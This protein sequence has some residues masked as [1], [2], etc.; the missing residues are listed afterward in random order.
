MMQNCAARLSLCIACFA[1]QFSSAVLAQVK[2]DW[3]VLRIFVPEEE[4][5]SLVPKDYNP[6]EIEDL[7]GALAREATRRSQL[8]SSPHIAEAL[9]VIRCSAENLVSDQSRWSIKSPLA[10]A[11]LK[12]EEISVALRNSGAT[13]ADDKPLLPNLR[14]STDGAPTLAKILGDANYWFGMSSGPTASSGNQ[15]IYD[16]RLP[17]ATLARMLISAPES[18][19]ITS[20]D[21]MVT[22]ISNPRE[23]LPDNWPNI[24]AVEGQRWFLI[25]L[26]GKSKFRLIT[27]V[28]ERK[29]ALDYQHFARRSSLVYSASEKG[30]AVSADFEFERLSSV[31]SLEVLLDK[32][33]RVRSLTLNG[34]TADYRMKSN[35]DKSALDIPLSS[36]PGG[37]ARLRIEAVADTS[38]PF[39][40]LLPTIEIARAFSWE[41]K[42]SLVAEDSLAG[43]Q[44]AFSSRIDSAKPRLETTTIGKRWVADWIGVPPSMRASIG[45]KLPTL[46]ADSFTRLTVQEDWIA[47]T[48]NLRINCNSLK[49]NELRLRIGSGWFIDDL[50]VEKSDPPITSHL[51][52]GE[53]GDVVLTWDRW[54]Y[55]MS[56]NLQ[57]VAHLPKAT[58]AE[59]F[60]LQAPRVV[61]LMGGSQKDHYAIEQ[62]GRF[63]I[64]A[65][66]IL[67][68]LELSEEELAPWQTQ[69]LSR[70]STT[71]LFQ[72]ID[73]GIPPIV[74]NRSSGTYTAKVVTVARPMRDQLQVTYSVEVEPTAGAID[75]ASCV[76]AVPTGVAIP[77]WRVTHELNGEQVPVVKAVVNA[78]REGAEGE[79]S[80]EVRFDFQLPDSTSTKFVL[81]CEF[82]LPIRGLE[83]INLPLITKPVATET[84]M[85][86]PRNLELP[87][88]SIGIVPLP[89]SICC[90]STEFARALDKDANS[91]VGYRYD[92]SM[93]SSVDLRPTALKLDRGA[94]IWS[95]SIEHR[96]YNDGRV[97]HQSDLQIFAP[98]SMTLVVTL[99]SRWVLNRILLD[100]VVSSAGQQLDSEQV[101]IG[102]PQGRQVHVSLVASSQHDALGWFTR[103]ALPKPIFS[104]ASLNSS[105][106]LWLQPGR[107]S[108]N[109]IFR[110]VPLSVAER[111]SPT[112]WWRWLAPSPMQALVGNINAEGWR[113][114]PLR[115]QDAG[116]SLGRE[117][118]PKRSSGVTIADTEDAARGDKVAMS[119]ELLIDRSSL[120][121]VCVALLLA[122]AGLSFWSLGTRLT[123]WWLCLTLSIAAVLLV[124]S[125]Y[126]GGAHLILLCFLGGAMARLIQVVTS[127]RANQRG[128]TRRG[129]T[130]VRASTPI[131]MIL[132]VLCNGEVGSAQESSLGSPKGKFPPTFGVL[133][134]LNA[135][136]ELSAKHVYAP[137]RLMNLL[138]NSDSQDSEEQLPEILGAKYMLKIGGTSLTASYVQEF[139]AEFDLLFHT[140]E[141]PLRLPFKSSQLQLLR[142]SVSVGTRLQQTADAITYR[143]LEA[144][145]FRLRL[146]LIPTTNVN[147][148]RTGI[149][150]NIPS[151]ASSVL[152]VMADDPLDVNVKSIGL[153][154]RL[155]SS[156]WSAELGPTGALQV[157]WPTRPQRTPMPNQAVTQSDTWL[158]IS[159]GQIVADCQIRI[160]GSTALPK[161]LH[162]VLDAGWEPVGSVWNDAKL[163]S[164]ELS[165]VGNRRIYLVNR[166]TVSDRVVIRVLMVPRNGETVST[167]AVPFFSLTESALT[168]R[169]LAFSV[170]GN[171]RWKL[172]GNEFWNRL[173]ASSNDLEWDSGK[174]TW[175]DL[176]RVPIGSLS[177]SLQRIASDE[178]ASVDESCDLNLHCTKSTL[179]YRASWSQPAD[180]QV[181]KLEVPL[182]AEP[183]SVRV[184]GAETEYLKSVRSERKFI[185]IDVSRNP[186]KVRLLEV[187]MQLD[188]KTNETARLPRIVLQDAVVSRCLY[189]VNCGAELICTLVDNEDTLPENRLKFT[190]PIVDSTLMLSNLTSPVGAVDLA[191]SYREST[192][193][194]TTYQV[195]RRMPV[196]V[197]A[198]AMALTRTEQGWRATVEV[199][200]SEEKT[201]EFVFFDVPTTIRDLIESSGSPYRVASSG[202]AGRS[203]L[204][205]IPQ[206]TESGISRAKFD[207]RLPTLG[208]SQSLSVP[209]VFFLGQ[210]VS[211]PVLAL[212]SK[213]DG[214]A[215]RWLSAGRRL[216][217]D[218]LSK[219]GL[220]LASDDFVYFEMNESQQQTTWRPIEAE[221]KPAEVLFAW[222]VIDENGEGDTIGAV[223]YWIDPS[224]HLDVGLNLP[225]GVQLIGIQAGTSGAVWH[226][227]TSG[228][229]RVLMQP[230][231]LPVQLRVFLRWPKQARATRE[232]DSFSLQLPT[233]EAGGVKQLPIAV[234]SSVKLHNV[235][236]NSEL[237]TASKLSVRDRMAVSQVDALLADRWSKLLLKS[238]PVVSDLREDEFAGWVRNWNPAV[239][240]LKG[241]QELPDAISYS[242]VSGF[243]NWYLEQTASKKELRETD[244]VPFHGSESAVLLAITSSQQTTSTMSDLPG[245]N[246][247][248]YLVD[249]PEQGLR[250]D[251]QLH[252]TVERPEQAT[253]PLAIA[254]TL[255]SLAS[256]LLYLLFHSLREST[257]EILATHAWLYWAFLAALAWLLVPVAWPSVVIAMNSLGMLAGQLLHSRRRQLSMRR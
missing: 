108:T 219:S 62:T 213:I 248:W 127:A 3:Q 1:T 38:F 101:L 204:C 256:G 2:D 87:S 146:Q 223:N 59:Q 42:T 25:H 201:P 94:W 163:I 197:V 168:S 35:S 151:I 10:N 107:I 147:G 227:D 209:D 216:P 39:D 169:T 131:A 241:F 22:Q 27:E 26:S 162:M 24:A 160:S 64:E 15:S 18:L 6:V 141:F 215:V 104:L 166:E 129:S 251:M 171:S 96:V 97:T 203:T 138:N 110:D 29:D 125:V 82:V 102:I 195:S 21:V 177:G 8:Q 182:S 53:V 194:P 192:L 229:V 73:E 80:S 255:L 191:N 23:F 75:T 220:T 71:Q 109:E 121:A 234:L 69:L 189:Q 85:I 237:A 50:T 90:D 115:C 119:Q 181:L 99:P 236:T 149:D 58:D 218:W 5:G 140:S 202:A 126:V 16:L 66:P 222:A 28:S 57:L 245:A 111:L 88:T 179:D 231:Y 137:R 44:L 63:Q 14:Y 176:W 103:A 36:L 173:N 172:V 157:D 92:P 235:E 17:A 124:P 105:Q 12:L 254:A 165:T 118:N 139:T 250:A 11:S 253:T 238:L 86:L 54:N 32:A 233:I 143:P 199:L 183:R 167:L 135:D 188:G 117:S 45:R 19:Q 76:L 158:H 81:Q 60:N 116:N 34:V 175:T 249:M 198:N 95:D 122:G 61:T 70:T 206:A 136:G 228:S 239:V 74:M 13:P 9:Y 68:R 120:C 178:A 243:W 142:G 180:A 184:N 78:T 41:G 113:K 150:V 20:P 132:L 240:G 79:S 46:Q 89:G 244:V 67:Q 170:A 52:D 186:A 114:I 242:D 224:N 55:E 210:T 56:I 193:L 214:Q 145:R 112:S 185:L 72:G 7:A 152:E 93:L 217:D 148:D 37:N 246:A 230:N 232:L 33:L 153:V 4:V 225:T 133:I 174:P 154:R 77:N 205:L 84:W 190:Q 161:Q 51:P 156:S 196:N 43:D 47:A 83:V 200:L 100:G 164:S 211:R 159:E 155:T 106:S 91:M 31:S 130:V 247:D 208:S 252:F 187:Q 207:F 144:G 98:E 134:P 128:S 49:S 123:W 30:L 226:A 65:S 48:T 212:P 40:D 257:N 221:S